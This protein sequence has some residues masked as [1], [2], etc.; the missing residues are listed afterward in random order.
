MLHAP[1]LPT[2]SP[3]ASAISHKFP[4]E[5]AYQH[6]S[7]ATTANQVT[8]LVYNAHRLAKHV[9]ALNRPVFP[10][11]VISYSM[12]RAVF[13]NVLQATTTIQGLV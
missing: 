13:L 4:L 5:V 7:R 9:L 10:A 12:D 6:V 1:I 2:A 3:A 11:R 8:L